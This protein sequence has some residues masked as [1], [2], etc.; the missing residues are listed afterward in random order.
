MRSTGHRKEDLE[1]DVV[2]LGSGG[3]GL[4][5]ALTAAAAGAKV[6]VLEKTPLLGGTTAMSG[7]TLWVPANHL[8]A[9]TGVGDVPADALAYLTAGGGP[10]AKRFLLEAFV[11]AGDRMLQFLEA[12]TAGGFYLANDGDYHAEAEGGR[13]RGRSVLPLPFDPSRL[14]TVAGQVRS[15]DAAID[16]AE[17]YGSLNPP[18]DVPPHGRPSG[19]VEAWTRGR[20]LVGSLLSGCLAHGVMVRTRHRGRRLLTEGERVVGVEVEGPEGRLVARASAAVVLASGGFEWNAQLVAGFLPAP[21]DAPASLPACEGDGLLMAMGVGAALASM[22][23]AWWSPVLRI[24]GETYEGRPYARMVVSQ[25]LYP[26]SIAVGGD[27]RRFTDEAQSYHDFGATLMVLDHRTGGCAHRPAWL[28]FDDAYRRRYGTA[29]VAP[30]DDDPPWLVPFGRIDDL[31]RHH[32]ID[33]AGL[34]ETVSEFNRTA[35]EGSDPVFGRGRS[36]YSRQKGDRSEE[37]VR[38]TLGPL[39]SPPFYAVRLLAGTLGTRGGPSVD[40]RGR[41][42]H[43][44]G[45]TIPGLFAVGNVAASPTGLLYPGAGGTLGPI[46]TSAYLAGCEIGGLPLPAAGAPAAASA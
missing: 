7:G 22:A 43:L 27:G 39:E 9:A 12:D 37:G 26:H 17:A 40:E 15:V 11:A 35:A 34:A 31:A 46:L 41:V 23:H 33:P 4:T 24:P 14:G 42:N 13:A 5:T 36:L 10:T 16:I 30:G 8:A 19:G 32:G 2:V 18:E 44:F 1:A 29:C 21:L 38:R 3:A 45:G 6:V 20:A 28:V 25:R